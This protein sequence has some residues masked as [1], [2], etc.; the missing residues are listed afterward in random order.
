MFSETYIPIGENS[1]YWKV[2]SLSYYN[3]NEVIAFGISDSIGDA[4]RAIEKAKGD[5]YAS[6]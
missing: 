1:W 4:F 3:Y 2:T 5:N 6:F